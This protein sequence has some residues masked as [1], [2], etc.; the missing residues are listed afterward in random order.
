MHGW[1]AAVAA[2]SASHVGRWRAYL[3]NSSTG[4]KPP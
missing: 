1:H 3:F 4:T 2:Q